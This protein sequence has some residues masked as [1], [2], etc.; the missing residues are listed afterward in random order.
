VLVK[1]MGGLGLGWGAGAHA[2]R[3]W[4]DTQFFKDSI[5]W[6]RDIVFPYW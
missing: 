4:R 1:Q 5:W 2:N 3:Y 6:R